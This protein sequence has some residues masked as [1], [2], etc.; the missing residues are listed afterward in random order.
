LLLHATAAVMLWFSA[1]F[2]TSGFLINKLEIKLECDAAPAA[3]A[4]FVCLLYF[5]FQLSSSIVLFDIGMEL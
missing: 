3:G 4:L 5:S 1:L 2:C